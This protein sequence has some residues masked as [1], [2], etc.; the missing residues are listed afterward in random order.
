MPPASTSTPSD[1]S[2]SRSGTA[3]FA[4]LTVTRAPRE[5]SSTAAAM[6]LDAA[7]PTVTRN[8]STE[9]SSPTPYRSFS[10]VRL[11]SAKMIPTITNREITFGSLQPESSK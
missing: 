4:S 10:V 2:R 9:N 7:P 6:P 11:K 3:G 1:A 8:P 5:A